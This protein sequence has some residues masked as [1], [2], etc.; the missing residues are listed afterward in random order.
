MP[1]I[2][3]KSQISISLRSLY[4]VSAIIGSDFSTNIKSLS[5]WQKALE[6]ILVLAGVLII[7][8]LYYSSDS[9]K[10]TLLLSILLL[11]YI[12]HLIF[13]VY[14]F[15]RKQNKLKHTCEELKIELKHRL[16]ENIMALSNIKLQLTVI[17]S[18]A[19]DLLDESSDLSSKADN[20]RNLISTLIEYVD[21]KR[22]DAHE[23]LELVSAA[24]ELS[25]ERLKV[26]D[27]YS[28]VKN[29]L[30]IE[31]IRS[32]SE[33]EASKPKL[34]FKISS[35]YP[36]FL[37]KRHSST[38]VIQFYL[39]EDEATVK[40]KI[41][42][43]FSSK[44]I[45]SVYES[46]NL[47]PGLSVVINLFHPNIAFSEKKVRKL[48]NSVNAMEFIAEPHDNCS[49]GL[50]AV[51]VTINDRETGEE[52][53]SF[54]FNVR[55]A[56]Y[57]FDHIPQPWLFNAYTSVIGVGSLTMFV[58][59]LLGKVDSAFGLTTG[60]AGGITAALIYHNSYSTFKKMGTKVL[61]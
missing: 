9:H 52:Y 23:S 32:G 61:N 2:S 12:L 19:N 10:S 15:A 33:K 37:S 17:D 44:S 42:E 41:E 11:I 56:D 7:L 31:E 58:L 60:T 38:I 5:P 8:M 18:Q 6:V 57:A 48:K 49:P 25:L 3:S 30:G 59:S 34:Y 22:E 36:K 43:K 35:A 47:F 45:E 39:Q 24:R 40:N 27:F 46:K 53:E 29:L 1:D 50:Q 16:Q 51:S 26:R 13:L 28:E 4:D 14:I 21:E 54:T 55:V 20:F